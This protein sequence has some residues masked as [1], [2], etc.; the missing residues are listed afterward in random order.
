MEVPTEAMVG[1]AVLTKTALASAAA[2]AAT[3]AISGGLIGAFFVPRKQYVVLTDR[4]LLFVEQNQMT[5]RPMPNLIGELPRSALKTVRVRGRLVPVVTL[6]V[7]GEAKGL[8]L[9][10]PW[11]VRRDAYTIAAAFGHSGH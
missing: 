1:T 8:K 2:T 11:P 7:A 6:S 3:L 4:R 9:R 10:V 5:G